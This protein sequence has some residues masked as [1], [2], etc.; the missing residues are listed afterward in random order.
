MET[1]KNTIPEFDER[2]NLPP[3]IYAVNFESVIKH[4]GGSKSLKRSQ[5]GICLKELYSFVRYYAKEIYIDGSF[6]TSKI[7]PGDIDLIIVFSDD[8]ENN[9][10]GIERFDELQRKFR[11]KLHVFARLESQPFRGDD[12]LS[13]FQKTRLNDQGKE[14]PKG[15]ILLESKK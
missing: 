1:E 14:F 4:F 6:I 3:G 8:F 5:L 7:S 9:Q 13:L 11:G 2:G 10:A 12:F 15:I